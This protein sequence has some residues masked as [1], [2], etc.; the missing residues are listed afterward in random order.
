MAILSSE[1]GSSVALARQLVQNGLFFKVQ[2][3]EANAFLHG[4]AFV[5]GSRKRGNE[6]P[7]LATLFDKQPHWKASVT[8]GLAEGKKTN[9]P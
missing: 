1:A 7:E 4:L 3:P 6:A 8:N 2:T 9:L 5:I